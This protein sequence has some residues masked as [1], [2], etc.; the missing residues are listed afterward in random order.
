MDELGEIGGTWKRVGG[1]FTSQVV[2][3]TPSMCA[4]IDL[5]VGIV[6]KDESMNASPQ[7]FNRGHAA[8]RRT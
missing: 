4:T 5:L 2:N 6:R 8:Q 3:R 7:L 1:K